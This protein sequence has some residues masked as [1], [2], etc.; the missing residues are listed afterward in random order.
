MYLVDSYNDSIANI[1]GTSIHIYSIL[2]GLAILVVFFTSWFKMHRR[3]I[4]TRTLEWAVLIIVPVGLIG[5]RLWFVLNNLQS[6]HNFLDVIAIWKGGIAIEGG[7]T[8]GLIVGLIIFYR[9]SLKYKISMWVYLDCII[10]NVLLGQ[11][12]GRWGNFFNQEVLGWNVGHPFAGLP[13]WINNHLHYPGEDPFGTIGIY[14]QP[15]FLY[16]SIISLFGWVTLTF[17]V[18]KFGFWVSKK[19]WKVEPEKFQPL[20]IIEPIIKS[21][22]Y[23]PWKLVKK[24]H[25]YSRWK[26]TCWNQAYYDFEPEAAMIKDVMIKPLKLN[27]ITPD[28]NFNTRFILR[29]KNF[30][31]KTTH[32]FTQDATLLNNSYNPNHYRITATGT[33]G[34]LYF[35]FYVIIR[36]ILELFRDD[37]DIMKIGN[38]STSMLVSGLWFILGITLVIFAQ[39]I[40]KKKF[41][42]KGWL[43]ERQY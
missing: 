17:I 5:A 20:W 7:V 23:Q 33:A 19:P 37:R 29:N 13:S 10:P 6:M 21:D 16:E 40:A 27:K 36:L 30:Y 18:P 35:A 41:R 2:M 34:A 3:N 24:I 8:F 28:M 38:V 32:K 9:A 14:R 11:A 15:L 31:H 39:I 22:Y 26:K 1:P 25:R 12:I 42:K 43:Y 4:P